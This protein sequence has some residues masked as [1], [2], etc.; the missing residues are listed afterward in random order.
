M[1]Y[2]GSRLS[3][4]ANTPTSLTASGAWT[5][6]QQM[7]ANGT[8][9]WPFIRDP[10]FNYVTMLL[11][12]DGSAGANVAAGAGATPTVTNFNADASTNNFNV[13]IN[14]DARS[15]NFTPYQ[16]NGYYSNYFGGSGNSL[17]YPSASQ[18]AIGTG[19]FT[20]EFLVNFSTINSG[21]NRM[22]CIGASGTDGIEI[23]LDG[24]NL[25]IGIQ[26][27]YP[28]NY[29]WTPRVGVWQ[30]VALTRSG[31][32]VTLY[33]NGVS[34]ATGTNSN[35]VTQN[36]LN[37]GGIS[38]SAG[39][40]MNG[41]L[42]NVRFSN[43]VRTIAVPTA[44]YT[45]D[46]NTLF[47][48]AQSN[49]FLDNSSYAATAT[50]TGSPSVAPAQPFTLP[51]SVATY[52]SG[53]FDGTGDFLS[54]PAS[55]SWQLTGDYTIEAWIYLTSLASNGTIYATGGSGA[56]DQFTYTTSGE[57]YFGNQGTGTGVITTNRW[58]HVAASRSGTTQRIFVSGVLQS[59]ATVTGT[60]GQNLTA[61]IG[62]RAGAD[63]LVT[64]YIS[65]L[66]LVK[67]TA[68]YTAA[69]TPPTSPL[70]AITNTQ[71]LTTQFNGAGNNSGF[72]D[73]SQNNFVVRRNGNTTQGTFTPYG[74]NWSNY[75]TG[76]GTYLYFANNAALSFGTGDFC[77]E[78]YVY[79]TT[80]ANESI[81]DSRVTNNATPWALYVDASNFPYFYTGT[82][83]TS[84]TAIV[85]NAWNH[86]A[87]TRS[88]GT[89][90]IFVNGVQG[91]SATV[92]TNLDR[93]SGSQVI[94]ADVTG[95]NSYWSGNI[96]NLRVV[97]GSAVYTSAFTPSTTPL[98]AISGTSLL[99]CQSNRFADAS[100]NAFSLT[101]VGT[102][103]I[104]RFS[105]FAN[106]T[107]YN[108]AT[109]SGSAYFDGINDYLEAG[110][111]AALGFGTGDFTVEAWIYPIPSG[112]TMVVADIT[113]NIATFYVQ[114]NTL[115]FYDGTGY[116]SGLTVTPQAWSH[117]AWVRSSG[118]LKMYVNGVGSSAVSITTN[119]GSS[120]QMRIGVEAGSYWNGYI[121]NLRAVKGRAVYTSNF[122]PP[123]APVTAI[124]GTSLLT[125]FTNAAIL[126]QSMMNDLETVGNAQI[127]TSVVKYGAAS[128]YFDGTGDGL[129]ARSTPDSAFGT[130]D[131]TVEFWLNLAA[132]LNTFAKVVML[133]TTGNC[134]T[135][136][137]QGVVNNLTITN[138][139][140]TVYVTSNTNLT[141]GTW[142]HVAAT[143]AS[144]TLRLFQ[145]GTQ[146]G[147]AANTVDFPNVGGLY[148]GRS[149]SGQEMTGYID[150]LRITKGYARYT[151]T[152]TPPTQAL[153]NG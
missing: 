33:I 127:S 69:F 78:A 47:L 31:S 63:N 50:L 54:A 109:T 19:N 29:T 132:T 102:P 59:T 139:N 3:A 26:N 117:V 27:G 34:V 37:L 9:T 64:G 149:D 65:D 103:S 110:P 146:V 42:S 20:V 13:T 80:A 95:S 97:K 1:R 113:L 14:G 129:F 133:G 75:F 61:Y 53:Y 62:Q 45:S 87:V 83:Y 4:T 148:I 118:S 140:S 104:Q 51:S 89:L 2:K 56:A 12:G 68:V 82:S 98:T 41:Y 141:T 153:P 92:T 66:R 105:P 144:G 30:Y 23:D 17:G 36:S 108:P 24:T 94:G 73:S 123:T 52:G 125:D 96:S 147:S 116:N 46:A 136:E 67:G 111:N 143:R 128:M 120:E 122:T 152:F 18:Y 58:L 138:K 39:F 8:S 55:T 121:S 135:I 142:I 15:N 86:I 84:T 119:L 107:A 77:V 6:Q 70:T 145:N 48:G 5:L 21:H 130:G 124:S 44:P 101:I 115:R 88:S 60:I 90:K 106:A 38:W 100:S 11:H 22:F 81:I 16:G 85:T 126:D 112:T 32:T 99:T 72:K 25:E 151:T 49:R 137:A 93:S 43:T 28:I 10:Q 71:L 7:Q 79:K 76:S 40:S 134:L 131:F 57:L 114:T 35:S 150:D 91:Y 74:S